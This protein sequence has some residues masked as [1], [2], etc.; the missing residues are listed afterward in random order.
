M[1]AILVAGADDADLRATLTAVVGQTRAPDRF[2]VVQQGAA[3]ST[4]DLIDQVRPTAHLRIGARAGFAA[5]V[6]AGAGADAEQSDWLW[7]LASDNAPE[8]SALERLLG[9]V[10]VSPSVGIAGPKQ[11]EWAA[12][13][14]VHSY[15]V[16]MTRFG[17]SVELA[18]PELDQGQYD[19]R[20]DVL[21]VA[22]G[23]TLVRRSLWHQLG[24]FDPALRT[25]DDAL[26]LGIR[27]RL[28]GQ[29][30]QLVPTAKVRSRGGPARSPARRARF[31]RQ[32]QLHR[33]LVYSFPL[34]LP[35]HWLSLLPLAVLRAAGQILRKQP[36][37][38]P[39]E[40]IAAFVTAFTCFVPV[41][42]GRRHLRRARTTGWSTIAP[43]RVPWSDVRFRRSL[44]RENGRPL[45]R[46]VPIA[47]L[48]GGGF[49]T[50]LAVLG[51][52][53]IL[54]YPL[55]G[56]GALSGGALAPL[57]DLHSLW[58]AVAWGW[59]PI[60]AGFVG[61]ADPFV[62]VLAVLGSITFWSPSTAI[63][64]LWILALPI[65]ALG[66]W[67]AAAQFTLRPWL[68]TT[69]ALVWA[70]APTLLA[71]LDSGRIGAVVVHLVAPFA[72]L[73]AFRMRRSWTAAAALAL[74]GAVV[75]AGAPSL[76][77]ALA[78]GWVVVLIAAVVRPDPSRGL[79]RIVVLPLPTAVLFGP[80]VAVQ[81]ARGD[82]L[83][84]L[85]D[86]G[87]VQGTPTP[88]L[89]GFPEG[90][91][92]LMQLGA[93]WPSW[94]DGS[95]RAVTA[96][97][98]LGSTGS[99]LL[100]LALSLP[101]LVLA[102]AGLAA[103]RRSMPI[104]VGFAG[105]IG[106]VAAVIATRLQIGADGMVPVTAW[107]GAGLSIATLG[108]LEA[109]IGGLDRTAAGG[110]LPFAGRLGVVFARIR[111]GSA[112]VVGVLATLAIA[113]AVAPLL[114]AQLL[115]TASVAASDG[116]TTPALVAAQAQS[117]PELGMLTL[118]PQADGGVQ[119]HLTRGAGERLERT[120]T[121]RTTVGL[122]S[123]V[124]LDRLAAALVQPSGDDVRTVLDRMQIGYVLL[125]PAPATAQAAA[126]HASAA[127]TLGSDEAFTTV[128]TTS[129]GTLYRFAAAKADIGTLAV[130]PTP[131]I[132]TTGVVI[133]IVQGVVI[134]LTLLL[135]LPTGRLAV[136]MR[137]ERPLSAPV[138]D[139][140]D[141]MSAAVR[142]HERAEAIIADAVAAGSAE[143]PTGAP[144]EEAL[145]WR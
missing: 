77:P 83:G 119:E 112:G 63:V 117:A 121:L 71:A 138:A 143:P 109:A 17:T 31:A 86:P 26:D 114:L 56:A 126:L 59:H 21:A 1:T 135:A 53:V 141:T 76:L 41:A 96:P 136:R 67:F 140:A 92:R 3:H 36:G 123:S 55:L 110:S 35:L 7:L 15:G 52:S 75:A 30:V 11:M 29:R 40:L 104:R 54:N 106:F 9:A 122:G 99:V 134:G 74:L 103:P 80:L 57:G 48:S 5:A 73:A 81:A 68:R 13:D 116:A 10:E 65:A 129:A 131:T 69:G 144:R 34:L 127:A 132:G 108:V 37:L 87:I 113:V 88:A 100:A 18:E 19:R 70:A 20:S 102:V 12:P 45:H 8:P 111:S 120:S 118:T 22:A 32:D 137:P 93:G 66:G 58:K 50:V 49:V 27:G 44:L 95:W 62:A 47:F 90:V 6:A 84:I 72:L 43:L 91:A 51:I 97:V 139:V 115:G 128:S 94:L 61:P 25:G 42:R 46:R 124:Q 130:G 98:G 142:G 39:A 4:A 89:A 82:L 33:R 107:P 79:A 14:Y 38:A 60:E 28:A 85:A 24:G 145:A 105:A 23:G 64:W 78:F 2:I 125:A 16:S 133:L 101:V